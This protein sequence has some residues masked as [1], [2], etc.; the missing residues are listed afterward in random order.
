M[1]PFVRKLTIFAGPFIVF[2]LLAGPAWATQKHGQPEGLY[3]HQMAHIFFII[4]MGIL[5]FWLRQ[6]NLTNERG[7]KYLQLAAVLFILWNID[8]ALVH[9]MEEHLNVLGISRID[10]WHLKIENTQG[11]DAISLIYYFLKMDHLL[12]VPAMFCLYYGLKT[13]LK[14]TALVDREGGDA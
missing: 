12:C 2:L 13:I 10:F 3:V 4:S 1:K 8:A 7:W 5:E 6:R 9:L 11:Q 14:N